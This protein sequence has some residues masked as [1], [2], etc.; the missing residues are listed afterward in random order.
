MITFV[1]TLSDSTFL[2]DVHRIVSIEKTVGYPR[3]IINTKTIPGIRC[4]EITLK[5]GKV[6]KAGYATEH[7]RTKEY[8][9]LKKLIL[10]KGESNNGHR[11]EKQ[12]CR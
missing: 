5:R 4:L 11:K 6:I 8:E 9:E 2:V 10:N 7:R 3:Q 1:S 12:D